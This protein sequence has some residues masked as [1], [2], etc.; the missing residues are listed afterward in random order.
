MAT[1][2]V[3]LS[4]ETQ[5]AIADE[6]ANG[7]YATADDVV[8]AALAALQVERGWISRIKNPDVRDLLREWTPEEW[9]IWERENHDELK[10][11]ID[12]GLADVRAGRVHVYENP[13]DLARDIKKEG[14]RLLREK[15]R[16]AARSPKKIPA[17]Q[18]S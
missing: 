17:T 12:E 2:T 10:K 11:M 14:R 9:A 1:K 8:R 5:S 18:K 15:Q 3:Q 7:D 6:L 16:L 13:G 4:P